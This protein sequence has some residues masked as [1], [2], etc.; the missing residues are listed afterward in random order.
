MVVQAVHGMGGIGKTT[1][2]I[3]YAHRHRADYDVVWWVASEEPSL[4]PGRLAELA[5]ALGLVEPT[6]RPGCRCR[7][8]WAR[9]RIGTAGC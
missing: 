8:C 9:C 3:E 4:I 6:E 1:L 7:V 5:R 2:A